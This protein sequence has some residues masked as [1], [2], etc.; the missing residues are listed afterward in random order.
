M[1]LLQ[2]WHHLASGLGLPPSELHILGFSILAFS[3]LGFSAAAFSGALAGAA[4]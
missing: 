3:V 2:V 4:I 1:L